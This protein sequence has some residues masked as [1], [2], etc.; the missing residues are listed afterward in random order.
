[1]RNSQALPTLPS[2][3]LTAGLEPEVIP[4]KRVRIRARA[5]GSPK[6]SL[7]E[8]QVHQRND[9]SP[10]LATAKLT[11]HSMQDEL[12]V[13]RLYNVRIEAEQILRQQ[14]EDVAFVGG[15]MATRCRA[16]QSFS[17]EGMIQLVGGAACH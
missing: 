17:D 10:R 1:M 11:I 7:P 9:R 3:I 2:P 15:D 8:A 14:I 6:H 13:N 4:C 16:L 12:R 5:V